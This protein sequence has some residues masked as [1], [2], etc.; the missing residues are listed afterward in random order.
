MDDYL[1][2]TLGAGGW[3]CC[4]RLHRPGFPT[5]LQDVLHRFGYAGLL[6]YHGRMYH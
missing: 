1:Y 3:F 2:A 5:L 4:D 6:A